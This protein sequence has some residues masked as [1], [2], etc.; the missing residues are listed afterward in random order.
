MK[1]F[2]LGSLG[3]NQTNSVGD[4]ISGVLT[5]VA[6]IWV[7]F[8]AD[9]ALPLS[10]W[11]ALIPRDV[12]RLPGIV[13]MTFLHGN[14]GH[15][16][17]NTVPLIILLTLLSGSRANSWQ[18]VT[19]IVVIGGALLW[20]F[21]RNGTDSHVVSHIGASLLV[22]GLITFFLAAAWFEMRVVSIVIAVLVGVLYGWSLLFGVVPMQRGVSWDGHLCGAVAGV[23]VAFAQ[24]RL[25]NR[26]I[27]ATAS[28]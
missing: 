1:K 8:F 4:E 9:W 7:A 23:V 25:T 17:S 2:S 20:L 5:F 21:G 27:S 26:S 19:M 28:T 12:A 16:L 14:F 10:E 6:V 11:F 24:S 13:A 15:L 18:T 22:F 3:S